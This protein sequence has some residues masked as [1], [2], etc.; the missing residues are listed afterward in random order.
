MHEKEQKQKHSCDSPNA[1]SHFH[2][3]FLKIHLNQQS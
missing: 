3:D 2:I 1:I